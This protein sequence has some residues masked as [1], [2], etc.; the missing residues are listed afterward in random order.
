MSKW[1]MLPTETAREQY[2]A[3][4][5]TLYTDIMYNVFFNYNLYLY[6]QFLYRIDPITNKY[7]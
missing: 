6:T 4:I 2:I 3:I 1:G 7:E 5:S